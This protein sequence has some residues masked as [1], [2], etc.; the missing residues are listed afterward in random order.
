[1]MSVAWRWMQEQV[2]P[3]TPALQEAVEVA[4]RDAVA[5]RFRQ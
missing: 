2:T 4:L 3:V 5:L 1:M